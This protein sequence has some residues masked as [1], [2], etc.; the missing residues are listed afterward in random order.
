MNKIKCIQLIF[1]ENDAK[2]NIPV[3]NVSSIDIKTS[4]KNLPGDDIIFI[5]DKDKMK[6][7]PYD[8]GIFVIYPY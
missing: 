1:E 5:I 6:I 3:E 8:T 7:I 4:T 2:I